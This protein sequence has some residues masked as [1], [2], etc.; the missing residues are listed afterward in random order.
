MKRSSN[1][2]WAVLPNEPTRMEGRFLEEQGITRITMPLA[3]FSTALI[4]SMQP[5]L[6]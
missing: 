3:D 1:L 5:A 6:A 2:H 4:D